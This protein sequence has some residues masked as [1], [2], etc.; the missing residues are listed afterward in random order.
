[1][2]ATALITGNTVT[3]T[4]SALSINASPLQLEKKKPRKQNSML[5]KISFL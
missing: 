1:M 4:H 3:A 2:E 5:G